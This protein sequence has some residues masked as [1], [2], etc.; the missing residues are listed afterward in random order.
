MLLTV[1]ARIYKLLTVWKLVHTAASIYHFLLV[2]LLLKMKGNFPNI[3][4]LM[5]TEMRTQ[6]HHR[7]YFSPTLILLLYHVLSQIFIQ[8]VCCVCVILGPHP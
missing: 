6:N 5:R 8:Q 3:T 4:Q 2:F 1:T 7:I